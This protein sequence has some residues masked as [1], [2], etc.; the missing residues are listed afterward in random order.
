M[1][2]KVLLKSIDVTLGEITKDGDTFS[3]NRNKEIKDSWLFPYDFYHL[4]D[5]ETNKEVPSSAIECFFRNRGVPENRE[6]IYAVLRYYG[7]NTYDY[8]ELSKRT[9]SK[10]VDDNFY[11]EV[12]ANSK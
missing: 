10:D 5:N 2:E 4:D 9:K 1:L 11:I 6:G 12:L 8:W 7:L 3:F